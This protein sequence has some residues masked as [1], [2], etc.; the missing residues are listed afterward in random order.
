MRTLSKRF[1]K[2]LADNHL[3]LESG[4]DP[5]PTRPKLD[6]YCVCEVSTG[7]PMAGIWEVQVSMTAA[8]IERELLLRLEQDEI[9]TQL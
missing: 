2:L 4:D 3:K 6:Y 7:E 5:A 8:D 1:I 9:L